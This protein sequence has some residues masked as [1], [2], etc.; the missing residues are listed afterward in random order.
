MPAAVTCTATWP[1]V[2]FA[3]TGGVAM[4]T[5]RRRATPTLLAL[6]LGLYR[7]TVLASMTGAF[8]PVSAASAAAW[9]LGIVIGAAIM[10][11]VLT[12]VLRDWAVSR[13][14]LDLPDGRRKLHAVSVPRIGGLAVFVAFALTV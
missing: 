13:G 2:S 4:R 14:V 6:S 1:L 12:R 7:S 11:L 3:K 10:A 8:Y 5:T 9:L